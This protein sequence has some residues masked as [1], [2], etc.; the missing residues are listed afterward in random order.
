[1][2]SH[3]KQKDIPKKQNNLRWK[4]TTLGLAAVVSERFSIW[5][6]RTSIGGLKKTGAVWISQKTDFR[7]FEMDELF[8]YTSR[9][10][11]HESGINTYIMTMVSRFPRQIVGFAVDK[12]V[13]SKALQ[14]IVDST[15]PAKYYYTDGCHVYK[16]VDFLGRLK[17]N[18]EDKSD[19]H[20]IESTNSDL[21]HYIPTLKR[22]SRCFPRK[23]ENLIAVLSA[24]INAY[25]K[26]GEAKLR[27]TDS[28]PPFSFLNFL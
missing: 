14:R 10:K 24:F 28:R 22:K 1:M 17:Q 16:D 18:F 8:W 3:H 27:Y 4:F 2:F 5:A 19:T 26:F 12:S 20:N 21:R 25:N 13:N 23:R 15:A 6:I 11:G 7:A 9:R